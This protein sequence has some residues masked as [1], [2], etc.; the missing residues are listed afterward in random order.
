MRKITLVLGAVV[1]LSGCTDVQMLGS[2]AAEKRRAMNDMQARA[3]MA[4]SCDIAVGAYFR[5]L[6]ENERR[7]VALVC[8]GVTRPAEPAPIDE[9][10]LLRTMRECERSRTGP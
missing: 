3:T 6:N 4:A 5:E 2:I 10:T 9:V 1:A 8:G 7:Y